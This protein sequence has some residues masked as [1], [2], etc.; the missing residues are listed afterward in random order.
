MSVRK[1]CSAM[2]LS[3][4]AVVSVGLVAGTA[5]AVS[6]AQV[7]AACAPC[8]GLIVNGITVARGPGSLGVTFTVNGRDQT[9]WLATIGRMIAHGAIVSDGIGTA[10]YLA[11][12]GAAPPPTATATPAPG[13][14]PPPHRPGSQRPRHSRPTGPGAPLH[15]ATPTATPS[16]SPTPN[17]LAPQTAGALAYASYCAACHDPSAPGFVGRT[18]YG[19]SLP[20]IAEAISEVPAMQFLRAAL[21]TS[22]LQSIAAYLES[23]S[24][25]GS[26]ESGDGGKTDGGGD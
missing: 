24:A 10:T 9:T 17:V 8:H 13:T 15:P 12:L 1:R 11:G 4:L 7:S 6:P 18:V 16:P 22:T 2:T 5:H 25:A 14:R 26:S 20:D 23:I 19:A 21:S 3:V